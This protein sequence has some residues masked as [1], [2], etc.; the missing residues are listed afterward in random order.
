MNGTIYF[1]FCFQHGLKIPLIDFPCTASYPDRFNM[2][3][4]SSTKKREKSLSRRDEKRIWQKFLLLVR[5]SSQKFSWEVLDEKYKKKC[6]QSLMPITAK[7]TAKY[8][9]TYYGTMYVLVVKLSIWKMCSILSHYMI[10]V[11]PTRC[12]I[13]LN[14]SQNK[15]IHFTDYCLD[16]I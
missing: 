4:I 13:F 2:S 12:K 11:N 14:E 3:R 5:R 10:V 7:V 6:L 1:F 16:S 9:L 8:W 15:Y